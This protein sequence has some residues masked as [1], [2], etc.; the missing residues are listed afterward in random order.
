MINIVMS[1]KHRNS[2]VSSPKNDDFLVFC[3][4]IYLLLNAPNTITLILSYLKDNLWIRRN[5]VCT[6]ANSLIIFTMA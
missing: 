3:L 2:I 5:L 4:Q 1:E 6:I